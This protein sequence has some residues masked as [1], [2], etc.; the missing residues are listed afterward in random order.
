MSLFQLSVHKI[1][2]INRC[3]F[4]MFKKLLIFVIPKSIR[5]RIWKGVYF[6]NDKLARLR[7]A[8]ASGKPC[9]LKDHKLPI[10]QGKY[11]FESTYAYD[12]DTLMQR[13]KEKTEN[14]LNLC[15]EHSLGNN[16]FLELGALDAMTCCD[17]QLQ[18][19]ETHAIDLQQKFDQRALDAG[20]KIFNMNVYNLDFKDESFDFVF[21]FNAFEHFNDPERALKEAIRV[22]KK[23]GGIYLLFNP[24]YMSPYGLHAES[25][26]TVPY[27]QFLFSEDTLKDFTQKNGFKDIDFESLNGW[28]IDDYRNLWNKHSDRINKI[29][30]KE[31]SDRLHPGLIIKYPSCFKSKTDYYDNLIISQIEI[32]FQ[33]IE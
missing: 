16:R 11:T 15:R 18:G 13:G 31:T 9:F 6:L 14:I 12:K 30:Y 25:S 2:L 10:L 5:K 26:I 3:D 17:L 33:K 7:F 21:S 27:C 23:G 4:L 20:V 8:C 1:D 28:G 32:L 22:T 19:K 24:L 29:L